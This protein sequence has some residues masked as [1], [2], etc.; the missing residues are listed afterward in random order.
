MNEHTYDARAMIREADVVTVNDSGGLQTVDV[1]THEGGTYS[2]IPV[3]QTWGLAGAPPKSG[4]KALLVCIGGDPANMRAIL[5]SAGRRMGALA[6]GEAGIY[7]NNGAR[8]ALRQGGTIQVLAGS[9]VQISAP[10]VTITATV[11]VTVSAPNITC[12]GN[13]TVDGAITCTGTLHADGGVV[14]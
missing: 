2:A 6:D 1:V 7:A 5:Y 8:V 10:N 3:I 13:L 9:V 14:N 11:G 12:E 4:L